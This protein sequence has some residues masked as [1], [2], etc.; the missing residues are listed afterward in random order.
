MA[1]TPKPKASKQGKPKTKI[2]DSNSGRCAV[3]IPPKTNTGG[4][5]KKGS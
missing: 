2:K 1:K 3:E 4:T 5:K